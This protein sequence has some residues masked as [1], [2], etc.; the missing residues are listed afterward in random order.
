MCDGSSDRAA[1]HEVK[2]VLDNGVAPA[3]THWLSGRCLA[4]PRYPAGLISS[5]YYDSCDWQ[6]LREKINSDYLKTKVRLRWYGQI[7][8]QE[9]GNETFLEVKRRIGGRR[10]KWRTRSQF[11]GEF[12]S[13]VRLEDRGLGD[14]REMLLAGGVVVPEQLYPTMRITYK[15]MRFIEPVTRLQVNLDYDIRVSATNPRMLPPATVGCLRQAVLET[16]GPATVEARMGGVKPKRRTGV[17]P[18]VLHFLGAM[19]CQK[20]SFSKYLHCYEMVR[21]K[22][23]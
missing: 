12:L 23:L 15:R 13:K 4:E 16:K 9:L 2:F 18:D 17:L 3:V 20:S 7:D 19:G 22:T 14:V 1:D 6:F 21:R 11:S 5:I 10:V 8:T